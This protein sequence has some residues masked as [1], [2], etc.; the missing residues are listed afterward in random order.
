[1]ILKIQNE[2]A[3]KTKIT[4]TKPHVTTVGEEPKSSTTSS[5][6]ATTSTTSSSAMSARSSLPAIHNPPKQ[7]PNPNQTNPIIDNPRKMGI[8]FRWSY[9]PLPCHSFSCS[10]SSGTANR[11]NPVN[12]SQT[13]QP[14]LSCLSNLSSATS[15]ATKNSNWSNRISSSQRWRSIMGTTGTS[16][17]CGPCSSSWLITMTATAE[18]EPLKT[19]AKCTSK[20]RQCG[21]AAFAVLNLN[22]SDP[23]NK[24]NTS[25]CRTNFKNQ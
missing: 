8:K 4:H 14:Q 17:K 20:Q 23:K 9:Q 24:N 12:K 16:T 6:S 7:N 10:T 18:S 13:S 3:E 2:W 22:V 25:N 5:K 21:V 19:F 1:M 15:P 11:S